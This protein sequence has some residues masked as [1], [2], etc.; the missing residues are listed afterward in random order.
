MLAHF[1][2]QKDIPLQTQ[3]EH[4]SAL[5]QLHQ[6]HIDFHE[7][8]PLPHSLQEGQEIHPKLEL[9]L[10]H[11]EVQGDRTLGGEVHTP[12]GE[13]RIVRLGDTIDIQPKDGRFHSGL[14]YD[15]F[16]KFNHEIRPRRTYHTLLV[17]RK[18]HPAKYMDKQE[19][20]YHIDSLPHL[21]KTLLQLEEEF[22]CT[23]QVR[24]MLIPPR[25]KIPLHIEHNPFSL[26]VAVQGELPLHLL[27]F[28]GQRRAPGGYEIRLQPNQAL[29]FRNH[30][31]LHTRWEIKNEA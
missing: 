2:T 29:L 16:R 27:P 18:E 11:T 15:Q 17:Q 19:R 12:F 10:K 9:N 26:L 23:F 21:K 25:G 5:L 31:D 28:D 6:V 22:Q 7:L 30:G 4:P 8:R 13:A 1:Y 20:T 3:I 24:L 14:R